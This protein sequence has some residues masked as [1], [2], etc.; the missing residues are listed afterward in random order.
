MKRDLLNTGF[1]PIIDRIVFV[2]TLLGVLT[3]VHLWIQQNRG[4][5]RGCLGITLSES[6]EENFDCESVLLS[7]AGTFFGIPNTVSGHLYYDLLLLLSLSLV[8]LDDKR[9]RLI[10]NLRLL[11]IVGGVFYTG[12][13]VY[14]QYFVL[15]EFCA[16]CLIS[17][18]IVATLLITQIFDRLLAPP[19]PASPRHRGSMKSELTLTLGLIA[20]TVAL[21]AADVQYFRGLD[22]LAKSKTGQAAAE[23]GKDTK[24]ETT[25][26]G[27]QSKNDTEKAPAPVETVEE[28]SK[29]AAETVCE[30]HKTL[31]PVEEWELQIQA[32]DPY[33]GDPNAEVV[34][35]EYFDPNCPHC[36]LLHE[37]M[38]SVEEKYGASVQ[39]IYKPFPLWSYSIPQIQAL[40]LASD[41]HKFFEMLDRQFELQEHGKGLTPE[42][43][44]AIA[45]EIG[46]DGNALM[47]Q[48]KKKK[49]AR[50]VLAQR[51]SAR[52][53]GIRSAPVVMING[54]FIASNSRTEDCLSWFIEKEL[55]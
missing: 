55:K 22:I 53:I 8:F 43:L 42:Q 52:S 11:A 3:T 15:G 27:S 37:T 21:S 30:Y 16:L 20:L 48:L 31:E 14:F 38:E 4:F 39:F 44:G 41:A 7:E 32:R 13:L 17:A 40:Y 46:M 5:D 12:Y 2:L 24:T 9:I 49:Y 6:I 33:K 54:K 50:L 18:T 36:K 29:P 51:K 35:F 10:K 23:A 47:Q 25:V 19:S 45:D 26:D 34:V 28:P 1:R